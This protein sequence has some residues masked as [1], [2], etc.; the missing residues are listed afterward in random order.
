MLRTTIP[1]VV[2]CWAAEAQIPKAFDAK[3]FESSPPELAGLPGLEDAL[4]ALGRILRRDPSG[5]ISLV[6][7][8]LRKWTYNGR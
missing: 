8:T 6:Y 5:T 7:T 4:L 1:V 3:A 2:M